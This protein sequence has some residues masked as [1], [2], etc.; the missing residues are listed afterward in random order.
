MYESTMQ[1][2]AALYP[3]LSQGGFVIIDDYFL[4]P[5]AQAV[6]DYGQEHSHSPP[7]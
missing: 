7:R 1:A 6:N 2:L 3:K 4:K 5:C